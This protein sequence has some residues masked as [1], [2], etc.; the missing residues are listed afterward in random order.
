MRSAAAKQLPSQQTPS[1]LMLYGLDPNKGCQPGTANQL[2]F[3][4]YYRRGTAET[5][6]PNL[7]IMPANCGEPDHAETAFIPAAIVAAPAAGRLWPER[8]VVSA[9]KLCR[10][11][12]IY[13]NPVLICR[14]SVTRMACYTP[15]RCHWPRWLNTMARRCM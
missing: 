10:A 8:P 3:V 9:G 14:F 4:T 12:R 15:N 13:G 1:S 2:C 11:H 6:R 5:A 7:R